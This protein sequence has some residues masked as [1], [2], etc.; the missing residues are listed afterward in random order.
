MKAGGDP[1]RAYF[2]KKIKGLPYD[3]GFGTLLAESAIGV[4]VFLSFLTTGLVVW[5]HHTSSLW[6]TLVFG[7]LMI[8][9]IILF[10]PLLRWLIK[11]ETAMDHLT[12]LINWISEKF[13]L[14]LES[15]SITKS[16][17]KFYKSL[18]FVMEHRKAGSYMAIFSFTTY[19]TT[20]IRF[21]VIFLALGLNA[22]W[23]VPLLGATIPFIL[24]LIP[25][26]PG[27]LVFVETGM[28]GLFTYLINTGAIQTPEGATVTVV[29]ASI[30][31]VERS[32]SY[33]VSTI[34]GG[35]AASYLG[36]KIWKS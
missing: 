11:R 24:G 34:A 7:I 25:F 26:S 32:I 8:L 14:G 12:R 10:L 22:S 18:Q 5:L 9:V 2:A 16:I 36:L 31:A 29:A 21:Y 27:G 20:I 4:L 1:F 17:K 35:I 13:S 6:I 33:L 3:I 19:L 30:V 15:E 28:M 23:Y